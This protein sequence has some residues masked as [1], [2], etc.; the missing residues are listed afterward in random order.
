MIRI[1]GFAKIVSRGILFGQIT[2]VALSFLLVSN[3]FGVTVAGI[4][5]I[6]SDVIAISYMLK[7]YFSAAERTRKICFVFNDFGKFI[8]YISNIIKSGI[9]TATGTGLISIKIW[10]IYQILGETGG[11]NAMTL[12]AICMAC[13]SVISMCI[14]GC[15]GAMMPI[16]GM[17]YG[18]KD[19]G[20]VRIL[21]KYVLKF[22]LTLSG[23]FVTFTIFF[24]QIILTLYNVPT[25]LFDAGATAL[26]LFVISLLGV[27]I[28]FL[29]MYYYTTIQR[30]FA[31][32]I[33]SWTEG[34]IVVVPAAW[35]L[36]KNFGLNGV[37]IA[38]ILA[39]IVGFIVIYIYT[40]IVCNNSGGKLNDVF[41][42]ENN[43]QNLL[44]DVSFQAD[45]DNAAKIPSEVIAVLKNDKIAEDTALKVGVALEVDV[46]IRIKTEDEKII[47]A[48]RDNGKAFNPLEYQPQENFEFGNIGSRTAETSRRQFV[49]I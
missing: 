19:F 38:F 17:L 21:V 14:A 10:A 25:E 26:R 34:I 44:Y 35:I 5:L 9:P 48:V 11:E 23:A 22:A 40:K 27:T 46:D 24:P 13:L 37:W 41:L 36:S 49:Q 15:N 42:I 33:L 32:N 2:N 45:I 18:E 20:G 16:V 12:Y 47:M 6:C 3:G 29:V 7:K 31:A 39:E 30:R 8:K 4:A 28:T 43:S 1:D